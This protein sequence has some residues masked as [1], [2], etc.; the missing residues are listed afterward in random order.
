MASAASREHDGH[1]LFLRSVA[2][3]EDGLPVDFTAEAIATLGSAV[4]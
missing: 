4:R 2:P 1:D 3:G